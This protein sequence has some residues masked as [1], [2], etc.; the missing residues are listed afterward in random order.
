MEQKI[1]TRWTSSHCRSFL[2]LLWFLKHAVL[3]IW[4][5]S[6]LCCTP[7]A[8][9]TGTCSSSHLRHFLGSFHLFNRCQR[10]FLVWQ[11]PPCA[12]TVL[13]SPRATPPTCVKI[14]LNFK[15]NKLKLDT[16]FPQVHKNA[17]S[18]WHFFLWALYSQVLWFWK[19][20][21]VQVT[22]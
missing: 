11:K 16:R 13:S 17:F 2:L 3:E 1:L 15:A 7:R 12:Q 18:I 9:L 5:S 8:L 21:S 19:H 22:A 4:M 10:R 14:S 20:L 6:P